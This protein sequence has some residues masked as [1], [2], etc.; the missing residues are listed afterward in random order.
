M[1]V[2][3]HTARTIIGFRTLGCNVVEFGV[4]EDDALSCV[5]LNAGET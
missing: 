4:Y 3:W 5:S 1:V 2:V